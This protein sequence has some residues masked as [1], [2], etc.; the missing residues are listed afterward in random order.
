PA[1]RRGW[2]WH[3]VQRLC[4]LDR[5]TLREVGPSVNALAFSPDGAWIAIGTGKA[6]PGSTIRETDEAGVELRRVATGQR[7]LS[8]RG[9]K[10]VVCSVAVSP[11]GAR[12]AAGSGFSDPRV[13]ARVT[14]WDAVTGRIVWERS[15]PGSL[16]MSVAFSPDRKSLAVGYGEYSGFTD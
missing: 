16:A 6:L 13:E 12:I 11:D 9:L 10:G 5:L 4:H 14:V 8:L 15:E 3:Y 7:H 2:E 1:E